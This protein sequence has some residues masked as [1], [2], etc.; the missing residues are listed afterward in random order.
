M[1]NALTVDVEDY[2]Q[3]SAFADQIG[4]Q[5]WDSFETRV[6]RNTSKLL[7]LFDDHKIKA[8]FF[9]LGWIATRYPGIIREISNSGHEVACHGYSHQLIY[10]QSKTQFYDET[11]RAKEI[12]EDI[13]GKEVRGYRAASYSIT[14]E[15]LWAL[16]VLTELDFKYDSS[17]VPIH[18]DVYGIPGSERLPHKLQVPNGSTIT[19][20]PPSTLKL[21]KFNLPIAGGGYFRLY[22]YWLTRNS[23]RWINRREKKPFVFYLHPWEVDPEQ[24]KL[25]GKYLSRFRHYNNLDKCYTRLDKLLSEFEFTTAND[26]LI[27]LGLLEEVDNNSTL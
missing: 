21:A 13:S 14:N 6:E 15:S 17:I 22:P 7:E 4:Y 16:D 1:K 5:E 23:L 26:V 10:K 11:R 8:T 19:E 27:S 2:F 12:L 25:A 24:P 20:F 9:C 3:V 18:H